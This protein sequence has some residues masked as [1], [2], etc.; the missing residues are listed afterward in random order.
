MVGGGIKPQSTHPDPAKAEELNLLWE[1]WTPQ[2]D[3]DGGLD[4]NGLLGLAVRGMVIDGESF[5]SFGFENGQLKLRLIDPDQIDSSRDQQL[6]GGANI[7]QGIELDRSGRRLA[8]HLFRDRIG[9]GFAWSQER[10]RLPASEVLHLFNPIVAGQLRGL[11]WF[12]PVLLR[13]A[14][15]DT[16]HDA[17]LVRQKIAAL[18]TGFIIDMEGT[19]GSLAESVADSF[20]ETSLEPGE[21]RVLKS[22]QDVRFSEPAKVGAEVIDFLKITAREI[23]AGLGLPYEVLTG[24]LSDVN[25]SSIRAGLV[26]WRRQVDALQRNVIIHKFCRPIWRRFITTA[27]LTGQIDAPGFERNPEPYLSANWLTRRFDWVDPKK[28]VEAEIAAIN[29][30]L[31]S[32]RQ[33]VAGRGIDIEDLDRE[34]AADRDRAKD[35]KLAFGG[36]P[37]ASDKEVDDV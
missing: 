10:V 18:L 14:D 19:G 9:L 1:H 21:M 11:S 33:A 16:A 35:L 12:A 20:A 36:E 25:Y 23:A 34:I 22:G 28:D 17:Q 15:L 37:T 4:F 32:R 24:D 30:G 8:Y 5:C 2:A 26:E 31:M 13:L 6:T 7:I 29:A 3:A 27:I